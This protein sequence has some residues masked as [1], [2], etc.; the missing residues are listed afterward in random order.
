MNI[1]R[2][3]TNFPRPSNISAGFGPTIYHLSKEQVRLGL[4]VQ[5]I[6]KRSRGQGKFDNI[7]GVIV[8]RVIQPYNLSALLELKRLKY[9][10]NIVHAHA[11]A[12]PSYAL[13]RS[14]LPN[15]KHVKYIVHVHGTTLGILAI[16]RKIAPQFLDSRLYEK[17]GRIASQSIIY[18]KFFKEKLTSEYTI[19][20]RDQIYEMDEDRRIHER[21]YDYA[22]FKARQSKH[23]P[24]T[25]NNF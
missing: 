19:V 20:L 23:V 4:K 18:T 25:T 10:P 8:H 1:V 7:D 24:L 11:T 3:T 15:S 22:K 14:L 16:C 5:V 13:I 12:C 17:F 2:L 21:Y 6:S 9:P